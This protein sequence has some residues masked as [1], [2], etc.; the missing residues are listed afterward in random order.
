MPL[1]TL[2][3]ASEAVHL[4]QMSSCHT[5][6]RAERSNKTAVRKRSKN[7]QKR[8]NLLSVNP[9]LPVARVVSQSSVPSPEQSPRTV[10][11]SIEQYSI[12]QNGIVQNSTV[13]YRMILNSIEQYRI[14]QYSIYQYRIVQ[15]SIEYNSIE[16]YRIVQNSIVQNS[17]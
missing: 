1:Q 7:V 13:Y 8:L 15:Y 5:S 6:S 11:Y 16:Q 14:V 12:V 10:Q 2:L 4:K 9:L 17:I 3:G